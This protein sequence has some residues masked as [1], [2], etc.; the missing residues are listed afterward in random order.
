MSRKV[1]LFDLD[2]TLLPMNQDAFIKEYFTLLAA[3]MAPLGY[4]PQSFIQAMW[5]GIKAMMHNNGERR[6]E[7]V[8]WESF[9]SVCKDITNHIDAFDAFYREDFE[10]ARVHC[11]VNPAASQ[12]LSDLKA[13]GHRVVLATSPV[14]PKIATEARVRWA[15]LEPADFE[16]VTTY[17]NCGYCKPNPAYYS[18]LAS[19]MLVEPKDCIMIGNDTRDDLPAATIGMQVFV[20]TDYL[21]NTGNVDFSALPHGDFTALCEFLKNI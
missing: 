3:K 21:I 16:L 19:R 20:L 8:F 15:G 7:E 5:I 17:E 9:S 10:K 6:N 18:D 14:Y 12:L 4:E 13:A 1:I 11:G 2:G